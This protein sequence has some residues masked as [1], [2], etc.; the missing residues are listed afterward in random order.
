V[1]AAYELA[2]L[3]HCYGDRCVVDVPS[4]EVRPGE[5]LAVVGP[6]GAGKSTL[7]RLLNFLETPSSGRIVY[8]G[9]EVGPTAPLELRRQVVTV[10]QRPMLLRRSV[11]ANIRLG[12]RIRGETSDKEEVDALLA[13]LGLAGLGHAHARTLSAGEA[14]RVAL[15]RALIV[16]PRVLLLD[17][18]T[19]NLDPYNVGLI[20][21]I[22]R[23]DNEQRGTTVVVVT[24]DILQARRLAHRTALMMSG[25]IIELAGTEAF[26]SRPQHDETAAFLRGDLVVG[27]ASTPRPP[28]RRRRWRR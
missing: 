11:A 2:D 4:L 9:T 8:H 14:Q 23:T 25:G 7:L 20:E 6:S 26:F 3:R 15:A 12:R 17:E 10:F 19:S 28:T 22:V 5:V 27:G 1:T 18:P 21:G 16:E 13:R 24:H